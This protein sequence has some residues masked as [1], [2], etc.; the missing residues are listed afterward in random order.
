MYEQGQAFISAEI[1]KV[2]AQRRDALTKLA[3]YQEVVFNGFDE[4]HKM[5]DEVAETFKD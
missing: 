1:K 5:A 3:R 2:D 4:V